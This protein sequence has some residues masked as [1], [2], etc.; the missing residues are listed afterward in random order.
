MP[1]GAYVKLH[2]CTPV[3]LIIVLG[4][5][6]VPPVPKDKP[7]QFPAVWVIVPAGIQVIAEDA[8]THVVVPVNDEDC[9]SSCESQVGLRSVH[10][11]VPLHMSPVRSVGVSAVVDEKKAPSG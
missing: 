11:K 4:A 9:A 3:F 10:I 7:P 8:I 5:S 6:S 2:V 1:S